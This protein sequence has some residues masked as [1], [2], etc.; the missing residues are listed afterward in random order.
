ML[1]LSDAGAIFTRPARVLPQYQQPRRPLRNFLVYSTFYLAAVLIAGFYGFGVALLPPLMLMYLCLPIALLALFVIWALPD[2]GTAPTRFLGKTFL[3][4]VV[5]I[6]LWP[7]Y[8]AVQIPGF[9]WISLRRVVSTLL[10]LTFLMGLS[11]SSSFRSE[12]SD[13]I[14][15][16]NPFW[17][18]FFGFVTLQ[19]VTIPL[20]ADPAKS[21]NLVFNQFF[22]W[23]VPLI[24]G[25][26]YFRDEV[27]R[28]RWVNIFLALVTIHMAIG[29][30]EYSN[31]RLLWAGH[32][33][34]FLQVQDEVM[35]R[36]LA[37]G[38]RDGKYRITSSFFV[39]LSFAE[40]L[41]CVVPFALHKA[42]TSTG[43]FR[44][45]VW[46]VFDLLLLTAIIFTRSRL[47]IVGW[48]SVHAIFVLFWGVRRWL[49]SR[50]D[51]VGPAISLFYP[52][53][54]VVFAVSMFT[55]DAVKFRTI[56][57]GSTPASDEGR[58]QQFELFWPKLFG[59]PIGHGSGQSAQILNFRQPGGLLTVD[60][61]IITVG[62][63]FGILG[64]FF[65]FGML[66][67]AA[68]KCLRL[69]LI[70][71]SNKAE[72]ALPVAAALISFAITRL[73][74]SQMDTLPIAY[75]L[76]AFAMGLC[77]SSARRD[78]DIQPGV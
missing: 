32:I 54:V 69:Y 29:A 43:M 2:T 7:D 25:A 20:S 17:L 35:E 12:V 19:I 47:G 16:K 68:Y 56:G 52:V 51:L 6:I 48:I 37:G 55:V 65:F 4:L 76:M 75:L 63:D 22:I 21:F 5:V 30:F 67:T 10:A 59:N 28:T 73:V 45:S 53:L 41:A 74:L 3:S 23:T 72:L 18:L 70:D 38:W 11:L 50:E 24:F 13:V 26:W 57:G 31:G 60:S 61:Y 77:F 34:G 15:R 9:A 14:S 62:I 49:K 58:R 42:F 66:L 39:S 33:P 71:L 8:L 36:I 40:Y 44:R 1:G 46:I 64:I 78:Q 27:H